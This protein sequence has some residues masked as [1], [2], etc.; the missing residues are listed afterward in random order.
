ME[1]LQKLFKMIILP[2]AD[3]IKEE[4]FLGKIKLGMH[5]ASLSL[6]HIQQIL[7]IYYKEF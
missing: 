5:R 7:R 6:E 1:E 4:V 2:E 3:L